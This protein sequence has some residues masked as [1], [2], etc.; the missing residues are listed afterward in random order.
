M[1][2]PE[3]WFEGDIAT[4]G[5]LDIEG[6][7]ATAKSPCCQYYM[8]SYGNAAREAKEKGDEKAAGLYSFL[9]SVTS[10]LPRFDMPR[11]PYGPWFQDGD[12]RGLTPADLPSSDIDA[13]REIAKH[14]KDPALLARLFDVIWERT[15]DHLA[16]GEAAGAYLAAAQHLQD[17]EDSVHAVEC[18]QRG[19]YL[20]RRLGA[21]K[22]LFQKAKNAAIETARTAGSETR[23]FFCCQMMELLLLFN[24]GDPGEFAPIAERIAA[25]A[26]ESTKD[27]RRARHY[28]R[29]AAKWHKCANN[30]DRE[31]T[32][33]KNAAET[34]ISEADIRAV[35]NDP[36]GMVSAHLLSQGIE[37]LR[38]AGGDPAR[39]EELK[40]RL[41]GY[42]AAAV[43]EMKE[44]SQ[45]VDITTLV[46]AARKHVSQPVL[47]DALVRLAFGRPLENTEKLREQVLQ[48][49]S[50][51]PFKHLGSMS[52][53]DEKGRP[54]AK[55]DGLL[56]LQGEAYEEALEEEMFHHAASFGW[57]YATV[58]FIEPARM[59]IFNDHQPSNSD[60]RF[61]VM[62]NPFVPPGHE[63]IYLRGIH[64]GFYGDFIEASHLLVPQIE[65]SI[66]HVLESQ[67]IDVTNLMSD[68]TQP[69]KVL[70]A[71]LT[72][73]ETTQI[74]GKEL[75]FVLR[76]CLIEKSGFDF[77]NKLAHGF[78]TAEECF[79]AAS[80]YIWWLVLRI[81]LTPLVAAS[82]SRRSDTV[83]DSAGDTVTGSEDR[84]S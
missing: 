54:I 8:S 80:G 53:L 46:E 5:A 10:F 1:T 29:V 13:I 79:S 51:Y 6:P 77:R 84:A 14:A 30:I 72:K 81:L 52:I 15:K 55:K 48:L 20:A 44:L 7:L 39:V 61:M 47:W 9:G 21:S 75:C 68:G 37:A 19:L 3:G 43:S 41:A 59:Q 25:E 35:G 11:E 12:R 74:F 24:L 17:E 69:V 32:A 60:L 67:G 83:E 34:Y 73:E 70:G 28:W 36:S 16:C 23:G 49:V 82:R 64:A 31:T 26:A 2:Q 71:L 66:R 76:G 27:L 4:I 33:L 38:R 45:E 58:S 65:N 50:K 62:N 57:S 18:L 63:E 56:F 42:Q 22:P 78:L 40:M